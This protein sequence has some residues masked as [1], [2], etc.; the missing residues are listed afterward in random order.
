[1]RSIILIAAFFLI[2]GCSQKAEQTKESA[3]RTTACVDTRDGEKFTFKNST[4]RD[5][6]HDWG[7]G[8]TCATIT[9]NNGKDRR[10]C[11]SGEIYLKC[12]HIK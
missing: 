11:K 4:V 7:S 10:L 1:M 12:E 8:E 3:K 2:S 6:V 9:D 5:A